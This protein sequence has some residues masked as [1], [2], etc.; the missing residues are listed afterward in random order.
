MF[1]SSKHVRSDLRGTA[2]YHRLLCCRPHRCPDPVTR[3]AWIHVTD[4]KKEGENEIQGNVD[5]S[6]G[7]S[8]R[9][10]LPTHDF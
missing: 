6:G 10:F 1:L 4:E 5:E 9:D 3:A 7:K 2:G 8:E